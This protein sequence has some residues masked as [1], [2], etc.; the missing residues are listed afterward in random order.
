[1]A[2]KLSIFI[3][4]ISLVFSFTLNCYADTPIKK[5]GRGLCNI[6]TCPFEIFKGI[7]DANNENGFL[8][9]FTWGILQGLF[10][11]GV[12]AVVGAYEVVTF[13]MP[14]PRD[15]EPILKD[16]EFFAEDLF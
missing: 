9:A 14:F 2:K 4:I 7:Q 11:T 16:P 13:P 3:L 12:R 1:M 10:K 6:I 8:A 5:L 15:Y